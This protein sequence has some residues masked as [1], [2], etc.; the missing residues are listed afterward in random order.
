MVPFEAIAGATLIAGRCDPQGVVVGTASGVGGHGRSASANW[1]L[2]PSVAV[3]APAVRT[4]KDTLEEVFVRSKAEDRP[5][6][7]IAK[8][9]ARERIGVAVH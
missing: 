5:T 2:H 3:G 1:T 4:E 7:R 8:E 9:I 6:N